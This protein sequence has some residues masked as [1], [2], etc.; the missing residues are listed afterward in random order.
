VIATVGLGCLV[1]C[2]RPKTRNIRTQG[3]RTI[4]VNIHMLKLYF[5]VDITYKLNN[6][7]S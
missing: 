1:I 6:E 5:A 7:R 3:T 2:I 4:Q